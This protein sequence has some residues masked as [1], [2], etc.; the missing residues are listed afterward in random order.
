MLRSWCEVCLRSRGTECGVPGFVLPLRRGRDE[1]GSGTLVDVVGGM[2]SRGGRAGGALA[3]VLAACA[4]PRAE[5]CV[6]PFEVEPEP[7]ARHETPIVCDP[8][9]GPPT[10]PHLQPPLI[11]ARSDD[12]ELIVLDRLAHTFDRP[13]L[14]GQPASAFAP[15][16][17]VGQD[18]ALVRVHGGPRAG[19]PTA[20]H[21]WE[22]FHSF[23][24][25]ISGMFRVERKPAFP[26][27][28]LP[29]ETAL[30]VFEADPVP[31]DDDPAA[32]FAR[33]TPWEVLSEC[34]VLDLKIVDFPPLRAVDF[35]AQDERGF[36]LLLLMP[37][38]GFDSKAATVFYGPPHAV[39]QRRL[40]AISRKRDGGTTDVWFDFEGVQAW[41]HVSAGC[42][43]LFSID[44]E[45]S[46]QVAERTW[47]VGPP[48]LYAELPEE[49]TYLCNDSLATR[50]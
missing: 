4:G 3:C 11:A 37:T 29:S 42:N 7:Q 36:E 43:G 6:A 31:V 12:G 14:E 45:G 2:W 46:L 44:C 41:F 10:T 39:Q 23:D 30:V 13:E 9:I 8:L 34:A 18:G 5:V 50:E 48:T 47:A 28:I 21:S 22:T 35:A 16:M 26:W 49:N 38:S 17:F 19:D 1:R 25:E 27:N 15:R 24:R 32:A 33:G 20:S 40:H